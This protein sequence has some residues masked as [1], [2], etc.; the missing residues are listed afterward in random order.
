MFRNHAS[1]S[2]LDKTW[3]LNKCCETFTLPVKNALFIIIERERQTC[4]YKNLIANV[5]IGIEYGS[6]KYS[7]S[8]IKILIGLQAMQVCEP[9][10]VQ[11]KSI[12]RSNQ[13]KVV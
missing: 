2:G 9:L 6:N 3:N 11:S 7:W 10:I 12:S 4:F 5:F 1:Q 8:Y 13:K